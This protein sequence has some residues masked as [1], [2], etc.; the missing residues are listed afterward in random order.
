MKKDGLAVEGEGDLV[1][2]RQVSSMFVVPSQIQNR[3]GWVLEVRPP[4]E[5]RK[6]QSRNK[7]GIKIIKT[8]LERLGYNE[9]H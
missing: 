4:D 9:L 6:N 2:R 8:C 7:T 3:W 1:Q 5:E